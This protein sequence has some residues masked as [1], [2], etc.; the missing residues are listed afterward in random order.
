MKII[1][2]ALL[3]LG[4]ATCTFSSV[5]TNTAQNL[6]D[7]IPDLGQPEN[8]YFSANLQNLYGRLIYSELVN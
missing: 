8:Q 2:S 6:S 3:F 4:L 5:S 1:K 7:Q